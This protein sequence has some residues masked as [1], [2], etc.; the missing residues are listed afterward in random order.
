MGT[1][2]SAQ[3]S[4]TD[5]GL[6]P[7]TYY[8]YKV[9]AFDSAGPGVPNFVSAETGGVKPSVAPA[10]LVQS[11][12]T[13]TS[14][15]LKWDP[16][17]GATGYNVYFSS[18]AAGTY[19]HRTTSTTISA[20]IYQSGTPQAAYYKVSASNPS[21]EGPQSDYIQAT[22]A[23]A[24]VI[25]NMVGAGS[26]THMVISWQAVA[27]ADGYY[28]YRDTS[29]G[30]SFTNRV[31]DCP[32][33][34]THVYSDHGLQQYTLY[35][36]KVSAYTIGIE[37]GKSSIGTDRTLLSVPNNFKAVEPTS[38]TR[39]RLEWEAVPNAYY[40]RIYRNTITTRTGA[41]TFDTSIDATS[42]NDTSATI[43]TT[44][45]YWI[46]AIPIAPAYASLLENSPMVTAVA[47]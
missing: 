14:I 35:Y 16:V 17:D 30:G 22:N 29:P 13:T 25:L 45:Y 31:A 41:V 6:I 46:Q 47:K 32:G 33:Q 40:Y 15:T 39:V 28:I 10:G 12:A 2:S 9:S 3:T 34:A 27:G 43:G 11:G 19:S 38:P 21:G 26:D 20:T 4:F 1:V 24:T 18:T 42:F 5:T 7:F 8:Y 44:Y 36:Y 23:P 37:G